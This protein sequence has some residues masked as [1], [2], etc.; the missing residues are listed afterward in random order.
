MPFTPA[1]APLELRAKAR[2]IP[3]WTF[4]QH[5]LAAAL[6]PSPVGSDEPLETV[7][8]IP[9]GCARLRITAFPQVGGPDAQPWGATAAAPAVTGDSDSGKR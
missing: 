5:G 3:G 2:K 6:R 7:T 8:L 4:D 1:A 9:M